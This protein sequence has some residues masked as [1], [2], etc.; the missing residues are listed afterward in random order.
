M[1]VIKL[2]IYHI[3]VGIAPAAEVEFFNPKIR[4]E[5]E[6]KDAEIMKKTGMKGA[7]PGGDEWVW[8]TSHSRVPVSLSN[9]TDLLKFFSFSCNRKEKKIV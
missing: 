2:T 8:M 9:C 5:L 7:A 1:T 4:P 3:V 6:R